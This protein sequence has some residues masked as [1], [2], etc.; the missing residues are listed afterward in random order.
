MAELESKLQEKIDKIIDTANGYWDNNKSQYYKFMFEAWNLY[1]EPKS[2]WN[3]AYNLAKEIFEAYIIEK[4]FN[5]AKEWLN[6]MIANNNCLHLEDDDVRYNVGKYY[7]ETG[8]Y[9]EAYEKWKEVVKN[10]G[11]RYFGSED[12]KYLDFYKNPQKYMK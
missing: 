3:Q 6:K 5:E 2:E 7:F 8:N 10:A 4:N 1:P 9:K 11:L 12:P